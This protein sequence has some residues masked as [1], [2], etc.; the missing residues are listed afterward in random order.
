MARRVFASWPAG[1]ASGADVTASRTAYGCTVSVRARPATCRPEAPTPVG[2]RWSTIVF[3]EGRT[4]RGAS[5][6]V[7]RGFTAGCRSGRRP[8]PRAAGAYR[9]RWPSPTSSSVTPRL[10][11]SRAYAP[12]GHLA[13]FS[14]RAWG[15]RTLL[16]QR[17]FRRHVAR[18]KESGLLRA[19]EAA[20]GPACARWYDRGG[21][22][23]KCRCR[24]RD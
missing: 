1:G 18:A 6:S 2:T 23:G 24:I 11:S 17:R 20:A 5:R 19:R 9:C 10:C 13:T 21:S 4:P 12:S 14:T 16:G 7:E 15:R 8:T 3:E 22:E